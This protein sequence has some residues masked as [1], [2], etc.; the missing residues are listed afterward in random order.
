M[1]AAGLTYG[2][3]DDVHNYLMETSGVSLEDVVGA[4]ANA[5]KRIGDLEKE[6]DKVQN[7]ARYAAN[8]ASC[9]ANGII[10]D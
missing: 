10:P 9:L 5:M 7:E 3:A 1:N 6:L 4:L 2:S 8:T